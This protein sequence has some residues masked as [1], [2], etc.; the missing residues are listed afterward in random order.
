MNEFQRIAKGTCTVVKGSR[1]PD[2][3]TRGL[4][5]KRSNESMRHGAECSAVRRNLTRAAR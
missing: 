2:A 4:E 1:R 3:V 5:W